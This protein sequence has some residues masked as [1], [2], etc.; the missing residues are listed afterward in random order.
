[1]NIY[2]KTFNRPFYLDRCIRSIKFNIHNYD[3]IIVLDDGTLRRY[4][5]KLLELHPDVEIVRSN[6]DDDKFKLLR[7][8]KFDEITKRYVEPSQFWV[9]EIE[10]EK[11]DYF[12]L[13]EDDTWVVNQLDLRAIE[14]N[15]SQHKAL[16][17]QTWWPPYDVSGDITYQR[18]SC[19]DGNQIEYY[20]PDLSSDMALYKIWVICM[21]VFERT[22][23]LNNFR[24][25]KRMAD[26]Q[27]Q[28]I[29][30]FQYQQQHPTATFAKTAFKAVYQGWA[31]SL[32][33]SGR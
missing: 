16:L 29:R 11:G 33:K 32:D 4:Q 22:Y 10:K 31:M 2:I 6:A 23:F 5:D 7:A 20:R 30:A 12:F 8:E 15:L 28:L 19:S 17:L 9:Q 26:E 27:T 24:G 1:M 18:Y 25:L 13:L 14:Q 3:R 21:A